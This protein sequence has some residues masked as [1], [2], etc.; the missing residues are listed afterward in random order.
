MRCLCD[1]VLCCCLCAAVSVPV[2]FKGW[3]SATWQVNGCFVKPRLS[4]L[5]GC[6][7]VL[8]LDLQLFALS[9]DS[10]SKSASHVTV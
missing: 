3:P 2:M 8:A 10:D 7:A 1:M 6:A 9:A 5:A 4:R